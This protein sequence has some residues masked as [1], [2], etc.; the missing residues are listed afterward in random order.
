MLMRDLH[1]VSQ[2]MLTQHLRDLAND[3]LVERI[4]HAEQ[5]PKV[6][7]R[8]TDLGRRLLHALKDIREF[9]ASRAAEDRSQRV[10][11]DIGC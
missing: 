1:G 3:G 11:P 7:Y 2:K 5:P 6:E 10:K 8:L 4:D 9:S